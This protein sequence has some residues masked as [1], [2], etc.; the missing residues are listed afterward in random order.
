MYPYISRVVA[1]L[2]ALLAAS[3]DVA[4]MAPATRFRESFQQAFDMASGG[5]LSVENTNGTVEVRGWDQNRIEVSGERYAATE[6]LLQSLRIEVH[7]S[8]G[9]ASVRTVRPAGFS[10]SYGASY[11]IH[12]P[13]KTVLDKIVST[14]GAVRVEDIEGRVRLS[15]TNGAIRLSRVNGD[16]D[17]ETTNGNV[18]LSSAEGFIK[19]RTTNGTVRADEVRGSIQAST[20]NGGIEARVTEAGMPHPMRFS[21]TN[22]G[23]RITMGSLKSSDVRASTTNGSIVL[24]LPASASIRV[25]AHTVTSTVS[26]DFEMTRKGEVS[27][28]RLEGTIGPGGPLVQLSTT[29]GAIKILKM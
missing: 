3:C 8:N 5:R 24:R 21:S 26:T 14:N 19:A 17:A 23:I 25:Q 20:T 4:Q 16:T 18:E 2:G 27:K 9:L 29:N 10:E 15:T 6:N 7:V 22:G 11:V 28:R 12:V 13:R 1:G